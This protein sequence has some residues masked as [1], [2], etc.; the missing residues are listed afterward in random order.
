MEDD[1]KKIKIEVTP[2]K[3]K[4]GRGPKRNVKKINLN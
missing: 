2:Q 4:I 3:I 1:L